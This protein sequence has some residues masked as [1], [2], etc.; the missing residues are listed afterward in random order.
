MQIHHIC[1]SCYDTV[2]FWQKRCFK[3]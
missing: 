3:I 1:G 2:N